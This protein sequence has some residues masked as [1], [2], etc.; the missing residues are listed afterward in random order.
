L[1]RENPYFDE[2]KATNLVCIAA[3]KELREYWGSGSPWALAGRVRYDSRRH[4][5]FDDILREAD[6][7]FFSYEKR[8]RVDLAE[9]NRFVKAVLNWRKTIF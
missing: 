6:G 1:L 5:S 3:K 8:P 7:I 9:S 2:A 4:A